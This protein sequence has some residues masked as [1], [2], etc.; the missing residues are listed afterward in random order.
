FVVTS[1]RE[2]FDVLDMVDPAQQKVFFKEAYSFLKDRYSEQN[3]V[4]AAVHLDEKTPHMHVGMVPVT[5]ENKLSAKQI[6]NRKE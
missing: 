2:F 5:E 6:F 1:D 3:I 4:H